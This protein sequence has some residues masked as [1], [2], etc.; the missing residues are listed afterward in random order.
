[1]FLTT[2]VVIISV[3]TL[4]SSESYNLYDDDDSIFN[5]RPESFQ[6]PL[7]APQRPTNGTYPQYPRN[8]VDD[9]TRTYL[10]PGRGKRFNP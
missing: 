5:I 2:L 3:R 10:A 6:P 7:P 4:Y 8:L 9:I 1:M